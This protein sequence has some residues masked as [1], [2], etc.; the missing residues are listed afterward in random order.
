V[1][2][3]QAGLRAFFRDLTDAWGDEL[4]LEPEAYFDLDEHTL[5]FSVLRGRGRLSGV[6]LTRPATQPITW[7]DGPVAY[8]KSYTQREDALCDLRVSEDTLEPIDPDAPRA[9]PGFCNG[10]N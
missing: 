10:G 8:F 7:R 1:Y 5:L 2:H 3:G 6:E 9:S 4:L